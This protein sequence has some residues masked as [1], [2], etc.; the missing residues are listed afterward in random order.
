MMKM[1][2]LIL[3]KGNNMFKQHGMKISGFE[4][5]EEKSMKNK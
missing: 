5:F 2:K 1:R 4:I 3:R